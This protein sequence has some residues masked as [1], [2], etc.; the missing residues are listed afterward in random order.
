MLNGLRRWFSAGS[1][2]T[3]AASVLARWAERG[4]HQF[5]PVH[6][7]DGCVVLG[8][9]QGY[10]WRMEWGPSQ[11]N[12]IDGSELRLIAEP[13]FPRDMQAL[14]ISRMLGEAV[15]KVVFE[16][17]V[18]DVQT[19][20]DAQTPPEARWLVMYPKLSGADMGGLRGRYAA[21]GN[22]APAVQRWLASPLG[23]ALQKTIN[24]VD[25]SDP[26]VLCLGRGRLILRTA[27]PVPEAERLSLWMSVFVAAAQQ[28]AMMSQT[29]QQV[30][31]QSDDSASS[32]TD[33]VGPPSL[34][35]ALAYSPGAA[36]R[37][38]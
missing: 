13:G 22:S 2:Q 9:G 18:D 30:E 19:R 15:E 23:A 38:R 16:Q 5:K 32:G 7:G 20:I 27:M 21:L 37:K 12:Y 4:S 14:V 36:R 24:A 10:D 33:S 17:Y 26:V 35:D 25:E 6:D 31:S 8:T 11:R 1:D 3:S 34:F 29:W 28:A